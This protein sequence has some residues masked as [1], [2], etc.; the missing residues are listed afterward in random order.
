MAFSYFCEKLPLR[1]LILILAFIILLY[2]PNNLFF[3]F[4]LGTLVKNKAMLFSVFFG[5]TVLKIKIF[6]RRYTEKISGLDKSRACV[7]D[8]L[9]IINFTNLRYVI[10]F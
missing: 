4:S 3:F 5:K 8:V 9:E 6:L 2:L 1:C 10:I 7:R